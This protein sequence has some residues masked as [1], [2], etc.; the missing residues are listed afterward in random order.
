MSRH[1]ALATLWPTSRQRRAQAA[2]ISALWPGM[3]RHVSAFLHWLSSLT[4]PEATV[5]TGLLV[6]LGVVL[7]QSVAV[8]LASRSRASLEATAADRM[9]HDRKQAAL[10]RSYGVRAST[11]LEGL[12]WLRALDALTE[13]PNFGERGRKAWTG[14]WSKPFGRRR[15]EDLANRIGMYGGATAERLFREADGNLKEA[16]REQ[17]FVFR[18]RQWVAEFQRQGSNGRPPEPGSADGVSLADAWRRI[19]RGEYDGSDHAQAGAQV[20][21]F[22][23]DF[24]KADLADEP[25]DVPSQRVD[26][27]SRRWLS[28]LEQHGG[29][30]AV[31][32]HWDPDPSD[33]EDT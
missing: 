22:F 19:Y 3:L 9:D 16:C 4:G 14:D 6:L 21:T 27:S 26:T 5:L 29:R 17:A 24:C 8:L 20:L 7:A 13:K 1:W 33:D 18:Q 31:E 28:E 30:L 32:R 10:D 12:T 15:T 2:P 11:Y 25:Y 23:A